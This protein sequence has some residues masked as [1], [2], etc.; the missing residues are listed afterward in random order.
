MCSI[1]VS[2]IILTY[3]HKDYIEDAILSV[4]NQEVNFEIQIIIA[5]DCSTDGADVIIDKYQKKYPEKITLAC[6]QKNI[7]ATLNEVRALSCC[8]GE[9]IAIL[10][11]DDYWTDPKKLEKQ[12]AIFEN[13]PDCKLVFSDFIYQNHEGVI[14]GNYKS[15]NYKYSHL[16]IL[17]GYCPKTLTVLFRKVDLPSILP[18]EYFCLNYTDHF[19]FAMVSQ[20]GYAYGLD[21]ST[22]VHR[23]HK[24][25]VFSM[26][27]PIQKYNEMLRNFTLMDSYFVSPKQHEALRY[28]KEKT[29]SLI[30]FHYFFNF[31]FLKFFKYF[32]SI[33]RFDCVN[34][35]HISLN[36]SFKILI[37]SGRKIKKQFSKLIV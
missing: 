30:A 36:L 26:V 31:N 17:S 2:I 3:N 20:D 23:I 32:L 16:E 14:I 18:K 37:K 10:D 35:H 19:L 6:S 1:K 8:K 27:E 29:K 28:A 25:G 13:F 5:D 12:I 24:G 7:G 21:Q 9:Y 34:H 22:G 4:I 11:G 33:F 15:N